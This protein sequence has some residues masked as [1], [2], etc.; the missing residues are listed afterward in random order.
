MKPVL[1]MNPANPAHLPLPITAIKA[2][3]KKATKLNE[4]TTP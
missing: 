1:E 2:Y 4:D 3:K